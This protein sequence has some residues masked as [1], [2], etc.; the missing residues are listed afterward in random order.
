MRPTSRWR[1]VYRAVD[2]HGQVIEVLLS[3][4]RDVAAATRFFEMMLTGRE[5]PREVTTDP[6]RADACVEAAAKSLAKSS[7]VPYSCREQRQTGRATAPRS[8][9][10][11]DQAKHASRR[12]GHRQPSATH[13]LLRNGKRTFFS[14]RITAIDHNALTCRVRRTGRRQPRNSACNLI[15]RC[16]AA[17]R[18]DESLGSLVWRL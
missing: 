10:I 18:R 2:Q 1:Y 15:G 11:S 13:L 6:S 12:T 7:G 14:D 3:K 5:R 4:R 9:I 17:D 8:T 16:A